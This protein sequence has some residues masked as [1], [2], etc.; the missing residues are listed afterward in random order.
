MSL[1][2]SLYLL[3][4]FSFTLKVG[5]TPCLPHM[6]TQTS[7]QTKKTKPQTNWLPRALEFTCHQSRVLC[8]NWTVS[9]GCGV[10]SHCHKGLSCLQLCGRRKRHSL[11]K[12]NC[13]HRALFLPGATQL[14]CQH[15]GKGVF[16]AL[17]YFHQLYRE[18]CVPV[19]PLLAWGSSPPNHSPSLKRG[20]LPPHQGKME[21]AAILV[22][23]SQLVNL[24]A[25]P[26]HMHGRKYD[27]EYPELPPIPNG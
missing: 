5:S 20:S 24:G 3:P 9:Y 26:S 6:A 12:S 13:P 23:S 22:A 16:L 8:P 15:C 17:A 21:L 2:L 1:F 27:V 18:Y 4:F 19:S 11:E 25:T 14:R 7:K 10:G